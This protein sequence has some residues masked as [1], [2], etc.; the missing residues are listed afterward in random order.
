M[1]RSCNQNRILIL[2]SHLRLGL[3]KVLFPVGL[4]VKILKELLP[5]SILATCPAHLNLL[6]LNGTNY[7]VPHCGAF[8][9]PHSHHSLAQ[10]FA[11][12]FRFQITLACVPPLM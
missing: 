10:I 9:T 1:G 6:D 5:S 12:G 7:E 8:S 3:P 11:S 4:P 2:S